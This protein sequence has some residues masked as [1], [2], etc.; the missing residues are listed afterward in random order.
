M[1]ASPVG[2][3]TASPGANAASLAGV[4]EAIKILEKHLPGLQIGSDPYKSVL[5]AISS[6]AK[7]VPP[8]A[9]VPGVQKTE[10][11]SLM[12]DAEKSAMMNMVNS[13]LGNASAGT[14]GAPPS[15]PGAGAPAG[16]G[17]G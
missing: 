14:P 3:P 7:F 17:M 1:G 2:V 10:A 13:S 6:M 8:S 9:E 12:A 16:G 4:R 5:N 15:Q 11:R